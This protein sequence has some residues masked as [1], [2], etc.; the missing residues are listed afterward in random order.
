MAALTYVV[1]RVARSAMTTLLI[2]FPCA[3]GLVTPT[4]IS[5]AIGNGA[6]RGALIEGGTHLEASAG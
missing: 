3:A 1:T 4:A 2:A 5:A 6:R